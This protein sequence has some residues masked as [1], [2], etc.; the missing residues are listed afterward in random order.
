MDPYPGHPH[1][2]LARM[3]QQELLAEAEA[4]GRAREAADR[5]ERSWG[6][7]RVGHALA[8]SCGRLGA[9]WAPHQADRLSKAP[10]QAAGLLAVFNV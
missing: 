9:R 7:R 1:E 2:V 3:R 6:P 4:D 10:T 8:A 5:R